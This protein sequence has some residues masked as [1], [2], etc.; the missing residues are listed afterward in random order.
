MPGFEVLGKEEFLELKH[1]FDKSKILF[2]H[3]FDNLRN[4]IYKVKDFEKELMS[5][6]NMEHAS[7]LDQIEEK[8]T[9]DNDI[10]EALIKPIKACQSLFSL[11]H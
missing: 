11:A 1:L 4:D 5:I 7:L 6:L 8:K 10:K 2:R 3:S 9:L